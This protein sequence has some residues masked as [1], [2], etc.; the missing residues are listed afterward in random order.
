[1]YGLF[2][3]AYP[4]AK[5]LDH[6]LGEDPGV[7][8]NRSGLKALVSLHEHLNF[9]PTERLNREEVTVITSVLDLNDVAVSSIMTPLSKLFKLSM[10]ASLDEATRHNILHSGY[11]GIPIHLP[12]HPIRFTGVLP[13]K[14]L[15]AANFEEAVTVSQMPIQELPEVRPDISV[16]DIF[17]VF[18]DRKVQMAL[19]T[20][21]GAVSGEPLGIVTARDVLN[22]LIGR[23]KVCL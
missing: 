10:D 19:V 1:M 16:Q 9:F 7:V 13:V 11:S 22:E 17:H 14:S 2:P 3:I 21:R 5:L 18:R 20:E 8:F 6:V 23:G 12:D 4:I 15:V